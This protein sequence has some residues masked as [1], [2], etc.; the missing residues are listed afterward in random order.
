MATRT[1]LVGRSR[2]AF[3]LTEVLITIAVIV[4]LVGL[5]LAALGGVWSTG[6]MTQSMSNMRQIS[7]WMQQY[8]GDNTDTVLPSRFD[9]SGGGYPGKVR[10]DESPQIGSPNMGTW[11]DI[12][13]TV[14]E[15]ESYPD[16]EAG[17][18][19]DYRYDSP[20]RALYELI[21]E[22]AVRSPFRSSAV[23]SRNAPEGD[24]PTPFGAGARQVGLPGFFAANDYFNAG[25]GSDAGNWYSNG[26]VRAPAQSMYLV[27]SFYGETILPQ[28]IPFEGSNPDRIQVDF[29]YGGD[30]CLMLFLDG[31]ADTQAEWADII[32]LEGDPSDPESNGRGVR[33]RELTK[34]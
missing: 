19:N 21:G 28:P 20:D 31:H 8:S 14:F 22:S 12:L 6:E 18:S 27:D 17:L 2:A 1:S 30:V 9:Y 16:G 10:S 4:V 25:W 3:T 29:R 23:N 26:Q 13:H 5:L 34:R 7:T 11:S 24:G 33:V 32:E 15:V